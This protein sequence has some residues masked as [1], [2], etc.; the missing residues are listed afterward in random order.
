LIAMHDTLIVGAGPA[1]L[2][3]ALVLA[4]CRR[5]VLLVD[6]GSPRNRRASLLH[7]F[8][9]RDGTPPADFL[10]AA[11]REV[12]SHGV[13]ML[14]GEVVDAQRNTD[15][16]FTAAVSRHPDGHTTVAAR[17]M[18]LAT[19]MRDLIPPLE[20]IDAFYGV[21]VHHCPYCDAFGHSGKRLVAFGEGDAAV[22]LALLLLTWSPSVTACTEGRPV[23][24]ELLDRAL[25]LGVT[26]RTERIVRLTGEGPSLRRVHYA[27]GRALE[28]HALFFNTGQAQRSDLPRRLG[29]TFKEDGGVETNDRLCSGVDG[30]YVAGDADR[31]VEFIVVAAAQGATAAVAINRELQRLDAERCMKSGPTVG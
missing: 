6:A 12:V 29:C 31:E 18:L 13:A 19:G 9:T 28:C 30:L 27:S 4:R 8:L 2:S 21:T 22:G 20:G 16:T 26:L 11:R 7:N 23:R 25:R 1:G 5:S 14:A 3:A 17:R 24:R 10:A 15:G